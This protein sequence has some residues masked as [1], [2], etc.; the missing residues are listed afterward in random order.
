MLWFGTLDDGKDSG[1]SMS[2]DSS[3]GG[4]RFFARLCV[5]Y[6]AYLNYRIIVLYL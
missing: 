2:G 1:S 4:L 3:A 5:V 6:F